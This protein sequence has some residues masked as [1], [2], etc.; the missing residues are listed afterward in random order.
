MKKSLSAKE[1]ALQVEL[2]RARAALER[3]SLAR[4]LNG[5]SQSMR[6]A[7]LMHALFPR[8]SSRKPSD[9]LF[10]ALALSRQYPLLASGASA[11]LTGIGK[12][13]RLWR[14]GAGLLLSWQVARA[15]KK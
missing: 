10:Q 3:Q 1:R 15:M 7:A 6:P 2:M 8:L 13:R 4:D 14:I 5:L 12:R 11:L 9:W